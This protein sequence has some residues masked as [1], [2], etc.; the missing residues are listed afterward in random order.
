MYVC[1]YIYIYI[2]LYSLGKLF[3]AQTNLLKHRRDP[4][5]CCNQ[6]ILRPTAY[7]KGFSYISLPIF[8]RCKFCQLSEL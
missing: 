1:I 7:L 3:F 8:I 5:V 4:S 2:Y 6:L